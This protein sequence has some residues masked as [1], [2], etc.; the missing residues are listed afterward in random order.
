MT[1]QFLAV[2]GKIQRQGLVIHVVAEELIDLTSE[3]KRLGDGTAAMPSPS[4]EH[5]EGSW[6]P[7]WSPKSRDF[8]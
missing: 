4:K 3:L 5:R 2:C 7:P 8:H 1:A 6:R